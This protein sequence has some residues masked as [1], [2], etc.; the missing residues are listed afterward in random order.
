MH[1]RPF[2]SKVQFG[3]ILRNFKLLCAYKERRREETAFW[4]GSSAGVIFIHKIASLS[5]QTRASQLEVRDVTLLYKIING[6]VPAYLA[7]KIRKRSD[8]HSYSTKHKDQL[9][10]PFCRT[11]TAQRSFFYRSINIWNSLSYSTNSESLSNFKNNIKR[12][13]FNM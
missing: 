9:H 2:A 5:F 8:V 3:V 1:C 11:T 7:N 6:L 13:L 10:S 12:K 4:N